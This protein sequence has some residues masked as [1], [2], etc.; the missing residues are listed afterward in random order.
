MATAN[1][2]MRLARACTDHTCGCDSCRA[3]NDP[4]DNRCEVALDHAWRCDACARAVA[5]AA[6]PDPD[7]VLSKR[8]SRYADA[9]AVLTALRD[10][11]EAER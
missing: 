7:S 4:L 9:R 11:I 10:D 1:E 8:L 6:V 5:L 3:G 2:R